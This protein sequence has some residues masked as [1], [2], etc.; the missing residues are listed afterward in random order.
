MQ[1]DKSRTIADSDN[2]AG[3]Q[4]AH[5]FGGHFLAGLG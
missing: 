3:R 4:F 1:V 2:A 5:V